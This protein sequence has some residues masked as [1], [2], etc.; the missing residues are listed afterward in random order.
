MPE[1]VLRPWVGVALRGGKW[2][3]YTLKTAKRGDLYL[4][5]KARPHQYSS[6]KSGR[7]PHLDSSRC[8]AK[9]RLV[10]LPD[11]FV[12]VPKHDAPRDYRRLRNGPSRQSPAQSV[13]NFIR[14][15]KV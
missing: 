12:I 7:I 11:K 1:R 2:H 3:H 13:L 8:L 9:S 5:S 4:L 10:G 6:R 14:R 15:F